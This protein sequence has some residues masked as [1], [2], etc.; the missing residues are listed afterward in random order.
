[1]WRCL[2]G[3]LVVRELPS[4]PHLL[5][6]IT[7]GAR[8]IWCLTTQQLW[9]PWHY[10][11]RSITS[12]CRIWYTG[13][14]RERNSAIQFGT[15][16]TRSGARE[17]QE[18]NFSTRQ[19]CQNAKSSPL[20]IKRALA[21]SNALN[22]NHFSLNGFRLQRWEQGSGAEL[23]QGIAWTKV[24]NLSIAQWQSRSWTR[25]SPLA[26]RNEVCSARTWPEARVL[27]YENLAV[28]NIRFADPASCDAVHI[29]H[30]LPQSL[31]P[32]LT[33]AHGLWLV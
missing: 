21:E 16:L 10:T 24:P 11:N 15:G 32:S 28:S 9:H 23:S 8:C 27:G 7:H 12:T 26:E 20:K 25:P 3:S 2:G 1:M 22:K 6:Y 19:E 30:S 5:S 14:G 31:L 29:E 33:S 17:N 4:N 13:R 18:N